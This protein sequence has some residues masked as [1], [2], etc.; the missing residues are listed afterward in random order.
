MFAMMAIYY[1]LA[2]LILFSGMKRLLK[3]NNSVT[4]QVLRQDIILRQKGRPEQAEEK[5]PGTHRQLDK[6]AIRQERLKAQ[7][8]DMVD[9]F[10]AYIK[11]A[12]REGVLK[13]DLLNALSKIAWKYPDIK[14][15]QFQ[16][17][18]RNLIAATVEDHCAYRLSVDELAVLWTGDQA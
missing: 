17:G 4:R 6:E 18:I 1:A 3:K 5:A 16:D 13:V 7:I 9:E 8:H 2:F 11:E 10:Q 12:A 15:S 14:D